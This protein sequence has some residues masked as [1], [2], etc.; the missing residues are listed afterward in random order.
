MNVKRLSKWI[1]LMVLSGV[2]L[3]AHAQSQTKSQVDQSLAEFRVWMKKKSSQAD[4][5]L[6]KEWPTVKQEY[7]ELTHSLDQNTR[8]MTESSRS[9]YAE[10]K[11]RYK[12]WE[13]RNEIRKAVD[14]EGK[15]LERWERT[16]TGTIHIGRIKPAN[17]RDAFI[18]AVDY[19]RAERRNWSLRD[20]DYAEFVLG[21]LYTRKTEVLDKLSNGDKIKIA[22]LQVEFA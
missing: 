22:A 10:M 2:A 12:E 19:T 14:L 16:M 8:S 18:R 15:E 9:E 7:K 5:T 17:L 1:L 3:G 11:Q 21:E 20:W 6:R 4:S 13:E